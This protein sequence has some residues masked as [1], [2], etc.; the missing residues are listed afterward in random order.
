[1]DLDLVRTKS[2]DELIAATIYHEARG[3]GWRGM[4]AVAHVIVNRVKA[5][6]WYGANVFEVVTKPWQFSCHNEGYQGYYDVV[7]LLIAQMVLAGATVDITG[8][9]DHYHAD[10]LAPNWAN[11]MNFCKRIGRHVFYRPGV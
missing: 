4:L 10:Y 8:G 5:R 11:E 2:D 6:S 9:A 7:A 1:M 3:E